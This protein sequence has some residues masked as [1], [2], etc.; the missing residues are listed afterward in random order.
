MLV[1][2]IEGAL[3][4]WIET[5]G[6]V[7][8]PPISGGRYLHTYAGLHFDLRTHAAGRIG[9][10]ASCDIDAGLDRRA[11][12]AVAQRHVAVFVHRDR[13][14]PAIVSIDIVLAGLENRRRC[15]RASRSWIP[16][17][18][19][20][21]GAVVGVATVGRTTDD[22][23]FLGRGLCAVVPVSQVI[24]EVAANVVEIVR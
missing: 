13:R 18:E 12:L 20:F 22:E 24:H 3:V 8:T 10:Q 7:V 2:I 15:G 21:Y 23:R 11:R 5:R 14:Q 16:E 4:D 9:S 17:F 19:P 1:C 6:A